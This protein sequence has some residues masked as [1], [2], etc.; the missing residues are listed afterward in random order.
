MEKKICVYICKDAHRDAIDITKLEAWQESAAVPHPRHPLQPE[1]VQMIKDDM[2]KEGVNTW[3]SRLLGRAKAAGS[4]SRLDRRAGEP[5]RVRGLG[6]G[7][8]IVRSY[9]AAYDY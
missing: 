5:P 8:E 6:P 2:A 9:D 3:S 1:G 4:R 7:A